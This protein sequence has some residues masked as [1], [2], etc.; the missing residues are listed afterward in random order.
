MKTCA[1]GTAHAESRRRFL[2]SVPALGALALLPGCSTVT[3]QAGDAMSVRE[4]NKA[5]ALRFKKAQ[6]EK[7]GEATIAQLLSTNYRRT[8]AGMEHLAANDRANIESSGAP[9]EAKFSISTKKLSV[10]FYEPA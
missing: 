2:T 7:D 4:R 5:V 10:Q 9:R 1:G 3:E 6:G 8:R